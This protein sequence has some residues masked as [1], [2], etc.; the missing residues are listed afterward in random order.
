[1][2]FLPRRSGITACFSG[3]H[4]CHGLGVAHWH[5]RNA[6]AVAARHAR[7][8]GHTTWATQVISVTYNPQDDA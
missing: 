3:C 4:T 7:A 5:S 2:T 8:T 6:M 1:M